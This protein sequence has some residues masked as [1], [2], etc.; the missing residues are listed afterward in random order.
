MSTFY[1]NL[2]KTA[3]NLI[4]DKGLSVVITRD[5][6]TS[7]P[8]NGLYNDAETAS[9]SGSFSLISPPANSSKTGSFDNSLKDMESM[10]FSQIKFAVVSAYQAPFVI[11][12]GDK[13][14]FGGVDYL[15]YGVNKVSPAGTDIVYQIGMGI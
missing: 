10:V 14:N 3:K 12:P 5:Y 13:C 7:N 9:L 15:I 8:I 11:E 6:N 1:D 2:A 4:A